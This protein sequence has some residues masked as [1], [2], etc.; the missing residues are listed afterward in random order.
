VEWYGFQG[1]QR[2]WT[3]QVGNTGGGRARREDWK[4]LSSELQNATTVRT[5]G[6]VWESSRE[7]A[8]G[9]G[10]RH[11]VGVSA[12]HTGLRRSGNGNGGT[13]D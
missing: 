5:D 12:N 7:I 10:E 3:D 4:G 9:C 1:T 13:C 6:T 8:D 11:A 2:G